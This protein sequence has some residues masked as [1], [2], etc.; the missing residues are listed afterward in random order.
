MKQFPDYRDNYPYFVMLIVFLFIIF[1]C[2]MN[3]AS[4]GQICR[5]EKRNGNIAYH[6]SSYVYAIVW[7]RK[8]KRYRVRTEGVE[9]K[10]VKGIEVK[11]PN[12]FYA[13]KFECYN[14]VSRRREK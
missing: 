10:L 5:F 2:W 6:P 14:E 12:I 1:C 11:T 3:D 4:A 7:E 9:V 13:S 8:K